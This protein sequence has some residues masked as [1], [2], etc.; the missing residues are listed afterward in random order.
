MVEVVL[1]AL[2][3]QY[4]LVVKVAAVEVNALVRHTER[5]IV[6]MAAAEQDAVACPGDLFSAPIVARGELGFESVV[7]HV[8]AVTGVD[9]VVGNARGEDVVDTDTSSDRVAATTGVEEI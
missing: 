4:N 2:T 5:P 6:G 9:L 8:R 3:G 7:D 1:I